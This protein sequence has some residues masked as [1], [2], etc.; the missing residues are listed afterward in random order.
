MFVRELADAAA[1][2]GDTELCA[3]LLP[4]LEELAGTCG[5]NG[6]L[7]AFAGC[8]SH[9]A[10]RLAAAL[11]DPAR[12]RALLAEACEVYERLGAASLVEAT[13]D[14]SALTPAIA[15]G[16]ARPALV[17]RGPVWEVTWREPPRPSRTA[18]AWP[19]WPSCSGARDATCTCSTWSVRR[20]APSR[21][22]S[23]STGGPS[24]RIGSGSPIWRG[25]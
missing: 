14:L 16:A 12:A 13:A 8:H 5:V 22:A 4:E 10:G 9:T 18:R 19:T 3:E 23:S 15:E 7:V 17:R 2:V 20:R 25:T 6:A 11:G 24:T 21:P 1:V